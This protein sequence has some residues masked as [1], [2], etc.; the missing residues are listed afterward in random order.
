M[1]TCGPLNERNQRM[2]NFSAGVWDAVTHF[3][4]R[5]GEEK[6]YVIVIFILQ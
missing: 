5:R 6:I 4:D 1:H 2:S 3:W